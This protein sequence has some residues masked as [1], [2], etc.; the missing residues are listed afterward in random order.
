MHTTSSSLD[1]TN[2]DLFNNMNYPIRYMTHFRADSRVSLDLQGLDAVLPSMISMDHEGRA[3]WLPPVDVTDGTDL[4]KID[5][6]ISDGSIYNREDDK[7]NS[8]NSVAGDSKQ[9]SV[10]SKSKNRICP[11]MLVIGAENDFI[12]DLEGVKETAQFLGVQPVF[13]PG[14]YHDV[15]LGPKWKLSAEIIA[16]W[17]KKI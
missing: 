9:N 8:D 17:V 4:F 7:N 5:Q 6:K 3:D 14:L 2:S 16:D 10:E 1:S 12:V 13:I 11:S 15:M